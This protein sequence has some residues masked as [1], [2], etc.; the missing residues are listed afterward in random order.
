MN[1]Y[2]RMQRDAASCS[3]RDSIGRPTLRVTSLSLPLFRYLFFS[4]SPPSG[5]LPLD[6]IPLSFDLPRNSFGR[7]TRVKMIDSACGMPALIG[8]T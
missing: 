1:P 2:P 7:V 8:S 3:S 6:S 5:E 4:P